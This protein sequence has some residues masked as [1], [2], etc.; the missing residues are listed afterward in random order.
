MSAGGLLGLLF[1]LSMTLIYNLQ[2]D[3]LRNAAL[4]SGANLT[5]FFAEHS[6]VPALGQNWL[7]LRIFI[8]S[9]QKG[10]GFDYLV[11]TDPDRVAR[12]AT[13]ADVIGHHYSPP[14]T[15]SVLQSQP[16]MRV[17]T[18]KLP[19][20]LTVFLFDTPIEFQ[21][22]KV[23][24]IYLGVNQ[25]GLQHVLRTTFWLMAALASIATALVSGLAFHFGLLLMGPVRLMR[26][27]LEAFGS[28]N[29]DVRIPEERRD[30][31]GEIY[32]SFN[33]MADR[34]QERIALAEPPVVPSSV[35]SIPII[36]QSASAAS[37]DATVVTRR[38]SASP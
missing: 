31:I 16:D 25:A 26:R 12:A 27:T 3:V 21:H 34:L 38:P 29:M 15:Q 20:G 22:V 24:H 6:A 33:T 13:D 23:G 1:L 10:R 35:A 4:S 32:R 19:N 8:D 30:E 37:L 7:S 5:R 28:G 9:A 36:Q 17:S 14:V 11:L 18:A 2:A